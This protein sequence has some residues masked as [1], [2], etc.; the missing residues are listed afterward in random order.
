M[1]FEL[2]YLWNGQSIISLIVVIGSH[3][4]KIRDT[5]KGERKEKAKSSAY[6]TEVKVQNGDAGSVL[7]GSFNATLRLFILNRICVTLSYKSLLR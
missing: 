6:T 3:S 1:L 4:K 7:L 5:W 2:A